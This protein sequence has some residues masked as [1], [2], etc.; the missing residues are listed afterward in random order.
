LIR[1]LGHFAVWT[2]PVYLATG[3]YEYFF[4]SVRLSWFLAYGTAS[5]FLIATHLKEIQELKDGREDWPKFILD[6]VVKW[7]GVAVSLGTFG[8]WREYL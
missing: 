2:L 1:Q 5:V 7:L 6:N 8:W 3:L 4:D